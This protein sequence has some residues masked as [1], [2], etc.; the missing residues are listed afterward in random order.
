[1]KF[2][3]GEH[4]MMFLFGLFADKLFYITNISKSYSF[5]AT[6]ILYLPAGGSEIRHEAGILPCGVF[7]LALIRG[8]ES[9]VGSTERTPG[10]GV[11]GFG[12]KLLMGST[13]VP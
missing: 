5:L 6:T 12:L 13:P 8:S 2:L 4:C 3:P 9:A 11:H 7:K 1:M 10:N